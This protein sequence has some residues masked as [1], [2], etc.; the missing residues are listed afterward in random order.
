MARH[1]PLGLLISAQVDP[2]GS[3]VLSHN[4][5]VRMF[6]YDGGDWYPITIMTATTSFDYFPGEAIGELSG[7]AIAQ[8]RCESFW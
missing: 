5:A 8:C 2:D 4:G 7:Y 6:E 3:G 1:N